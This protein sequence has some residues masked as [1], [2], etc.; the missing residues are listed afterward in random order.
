M[1]E[2]Q[3]NRIKHLDLDFQRAVYHQFLELMSRQDIN[4]AYEVY[5]EIHVDG[6]IH[7]DAVDRLKINCPN[8]VLRI[9]TRLGQMYFK[10]K[11][12]NYASTTKQSSESNGKTEGSRKQN[13]TGRKGSVHT[14]VTK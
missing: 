13:N 1:T 4:L 14:V 2:Q 10:Y 5:K 9:M 7:P 8:C 11:E 3:F 12:E 6:G